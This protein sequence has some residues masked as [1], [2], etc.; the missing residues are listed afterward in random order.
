MQNNEQSCIG[1]KRFLVQEGIYDVFK[2][3]VQEEFSKVV[4][5]RPMR[6]E[7]YFGPLSLE[8]QKNTVELQIKDLESSFSEKAKET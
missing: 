1:S 3:I 5:G 4:T 8:E 2:E 6:K 7:T